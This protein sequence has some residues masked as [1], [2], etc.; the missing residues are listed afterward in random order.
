[1]T[2]DFVDSWNAFN[3]K[4]T[5]VETTKSRNEYLPTIP[6]P[7]DDSICKYY[8]DYINDLA[9][10]LHLEHIFVHCGQAVFTKCHK[11]CGKS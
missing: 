4:V 7:P 3:K 6:H 9:D 2:H 8:L 5:S 10:S 11:S 1:M